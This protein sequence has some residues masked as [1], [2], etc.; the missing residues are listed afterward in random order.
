MKELADTREP[1][2]STALWLSCSLAA[3]GGYAD[4]A[5]F[6]VAGTFTGHI[7][8]N[9]VLATV[10]A[11]ARDWNA[12]ALNALAVG[13]FVTAS[14]LAMIVHERLSRK[15]PWSVITTV[16]LAEIALFL[17]IAI[18]SWHLHDVSRMILVLLA[19]TALGLQNGTLTKAGGVSV[20][21]TFITGMA[22]TL[23]HNLAIQ[24]QGSSS[25]D[26]SGVKENVHFDLSI[27][28]CFLMGALTAALMNRSLHPYLFLPLIA[29][30]ATVAITF[31]INA[32]DP[33]KR[34]I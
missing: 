4:T 3:V 10:H 34:R 6:V 17:P 15:L 29:F 31:Q 33:S 13:T 16:L 9:S 26:K 28:I 24:L 19:C 23:L 14:F 11:A 20:H 8:G 21:T 30:L 12:L 2:S 32:K 7:T 25:Q 5:V 1:G 18:A 22:T 27:W